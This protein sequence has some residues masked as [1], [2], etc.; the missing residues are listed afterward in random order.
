[1]TAPDNRD[2]NQSNS[3]PIL[4]TLYCEDDIDDGRGKGFFFIPAY[5]KH[6][7]NHPNQKVGLLFVWHTVSWRPENSLASTVA[8]LSTRPNNF[9]LFKTGKLRERQ[10]IARQSHV[11]STTPHCTVHQR[12]WA[13]SN[14][15]KPICL[16]KV[17]LHEWQMRIEETADKIMPAANQSTFMVSS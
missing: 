10:R 1:M 2:S 11:L 5:N 17:Y 14:Q 8:S 3:I 16:D 13:D 12:S 15:I 9:S 7:W 6:A 4:L